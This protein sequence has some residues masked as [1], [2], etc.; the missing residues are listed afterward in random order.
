MKRLRNAAALAI[1][2]ALAIA[3]ADAGTTW[4][5]ISA[6]IF[7]MVCPGPTT[8]GCDTSSGLYGHQG[9]AYPAT[10]EAK[11]Q[12]ARVASLS[13]DELLVACKDAYPQITMREPGAPALTQAAL[14]TNFAAIAQCANERYGV[15]PVW[16]PQLVD[17]VDICQLKM[18]DGWRLIRE[19]DI[20]ALSD[21]NSVFLESTLTS[22]GTVPGNLFFS[23]TVYV[24]GADGAL[25]LGS[26]ASGQST[27]VWDLPVPLAD[28]TYAGYGGPYAYTTAALRCIHTAMMY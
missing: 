11:E 5:Y 12:L 4:V 1:L 15:R 16:I 24:R 20:N 19:S 10:R 9:P 14:A 18:G 26:L 13:F 6:P 8:G 25:K 7:P 2:C 22:A 27:R 28:R 23:L 3:R 17:D 21:R